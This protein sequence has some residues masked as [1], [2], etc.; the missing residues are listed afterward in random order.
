MTCYDIRSLALKNIYQLFN[1]IHILLN[2]SSKCLENAKYMYE[3]FRRVCKG[4][5]ETRHWLRVKL[6]KKR[7]SL[8]CS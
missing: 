7:R 1:L 4:K 3:K 2:V 8:I 5:A 6:A